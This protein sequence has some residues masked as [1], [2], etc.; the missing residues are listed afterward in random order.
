M[1]HVL[2]CQLVTGVLLI[3]AE[4]GFFKQHFLLMNL[5]LLFTRYN[6]IFAGGYG[7]VQ[8]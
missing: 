8:K 4:Q 2:L 1:S 5:A 7:C 6:K 3:I